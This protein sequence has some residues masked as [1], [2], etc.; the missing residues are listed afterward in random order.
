MKQLPALAA[1]LA[2]AASAGACGTRPRPDIVLILIDTLRRDHLPFHGYDKDT[3]PFLGELARRG[4]AFENAYSTSAWTAPAA[5]TLFTSLY[6][7]QHGLVTGR[8]AVARM[9][10]QGVPIKVNR[11]PEAAETI[12]EVLKSAGY[13]TW[14]VV[15]NVNLSREL[16]FDQGFDEFHSLHPS[17]DAA[18]ITRK[19]EELHPRIVAKRPYFLYLHYM[20]VHAP[21][22]D[23]PPLFDQSLE[24]ETRRVSAYDS[25]IFYLDGHIRSAFERFGWERGAV[26]VVTADHGEELGERGFFGHARTLFAEVL[27]VPLLFHGVAAAPTGGRVRERV[28]HVDVLPTLRELLGLPRGALDAGLSLVPLLEGRRDALPER[29]L[30][31]DLWRNPGGE[32]RPLLRATIH[33]RWKRIKGS[34]EGPLLFDLDADPRDLRNVARDHPAVEADL[35]RRFAEFEAWAPRLEPAFAESVIDEATNEALKAL[36]YVN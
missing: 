23:R 33:G 9:T 34:A 4:T 19:L 28:S 21:Y 35:K 26:L 29:A 3:A 24:G 25:E 13:A 30:F 14:A 20:D 8:M 36:G 6:P 15:E 32:R 31:A 12:A 11:V 17:L 1:V 22:K 5:A 7:L 2:L 16:G 10:R 18:T 27:N